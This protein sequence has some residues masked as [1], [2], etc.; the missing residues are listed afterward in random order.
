MFG[1]LARAITGAVKGDMWWLEGGAA[2]G[3]LPHC[4]TACVDAEAAAPGP[5]DLQSGWNNSLRV[6]EAGAKAAKEL[7]AKQDFAAKEKARLDAVAELLKAK[8]LEMTAQVGLSFCVRG[9]RDRG[10]KSFN[11][12]EEGIRK[13]WLAV[14]G[15]AGARALCCGGGCSFFIHARMSTTCTHAHST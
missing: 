2:P 13:T 14:D 4:L 7:E 9:G 6:Q 8:R 5:F 15:I 11:K 12:R 10:V 1:A 3:T